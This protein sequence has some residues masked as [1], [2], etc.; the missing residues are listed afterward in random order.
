MEDHIAALIHSMTIEEKV[1]QLC[2]IRTRNFVDADGKFDPAKAEPLLQHGA[3]SC[4]PVRLP[5]EQEVEFRNAMQK[6]LRE[7]TPHGIPVLFH[8]EGCHGVLAPEATSFPAPIGLACSWDI[9]LTERIFAAVG[10]ELRSR[11]IHHA[12]APV[13]DTNYDARWGRTDEMMG[14]DPFLN[15]MLGIAMVRGMQ[16]DDPTHIGDG[17]VATTLKHLA[18]HG[19]PEAGINRAPA[20]LGMRELYELHLAPFRDV[21]A[22]AHPATVM[23]SYNEI[24][25]LPS[26]ANRWLLQDVLR[27]EFGFDGLVVSD[28]H[29]V[30]ELFRCHHVAADDPEAALRAF[31]VG[32]DT[33]LPLG[34]HYAL[35]SGLVREGKLAESAL[36]ES[37]AR[38]LRLKFAVGLFEDSTADAAKAMKIAN[39]NSSKALAREA[40]Q[41]SIVLLK[42]KSNLLPLDKDGYETIAVIGPHSD[43]ARLGGYCGEPL[44]RVSLLEGIKNHVGDFA[45]VVHAKGCLLTTN[46]GSPRN[47][48][49]K[50]RMQEFPSPE[51][52]QA[53]IAQATEL[54]KTSDLIVLVI[55]DNE[56]ICRE[57]WSADHIGDRASLDLFGAQNELAEAI[58]RLGKPVIVYL[59][60]GRPLAIPHII[61]KAHAVLEGWYMGQET[62]NAAADILFG[63]VNPSGKLTMTIPRSVGQVPIYYNQKP[64]ARGFRYMDLD[65]SPLFP[66]GFGLSYTTFGYEEPRLSNHEIPL[67][68]KAEVSVKLTNTG[69][70]HGDEIVQLYIHDI[71]ASVTRPVKELKGFQRVSL[72]PG[73]SKTVSFS[74]TPDML[75]FYNEDLRRIVE[76][77]DFEIIV[78]PSSAEGK[79]ITLRVVEADR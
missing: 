19:F 32:V 31:N 38:V 6:Y 41:K 46:E 72:A 36:D 9:D 34:E 74:I 3:G 21:I 67:N 70:R 24:D 17:K 63:D 12:L 77:G 4:D 13:I 58:F 66:F 14:E 48:W 27:K 62:G 65:N 51:E 61:E 71:V 53:L 55:G 18:G 44:Y 79:S 33:D 35:L 60:N 56:L 45:K 5:I 69:N 59:M 78:G 50:V 1:A 22:E 75:S 54:A 76:P 2:C 8:E 49:D 68:G 37:A 7:K 20:H 64:S 73:A 25:G 15:T 11:G 42:N 16:G 57:A 52:N 43:D 28:Y 10:S 26:H 30:R 40:A 47:S 23:P 39:L 29:G